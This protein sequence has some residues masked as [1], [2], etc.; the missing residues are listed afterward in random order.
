MSNPFD[1]PKLHSDLPIYGLQSQLL[2]VTAATVAGPSGIAQVAGSSVLAPIL[3]VA[4]TQQMRPDSLLP[5]D[6]EPCLV[7]AV[8][9]FALTP[10]FHLG[11][12]A[13]SHNSLPVYEVVEVGLSGSVGP[14]GPQGPQGLTGATG[15]TGS[16]GTQGTTG[17]T[18]STGNPGTPGTPGGP[19]GPAGSQG[20]PGTQGTTGATGS[21]GNPGTQGSPGATG[22]TGNPGTQ[23]SP[24]PTGSKGDPGTQGSRGPTGS[25]GNPG[26]QGSPGPTGSKGDPGTQGAQGPA[27]SFA[28]ARVYDSATINVDTGTSVALTFDSERYDEGSY[29]SISVNTTR[30]TVPTS[31]GGVHHIGGQINFPPPGT[32][33][34]RRTVTI[35]LNGTTDIASAQV[36]PIT[37]ISDGTNVHI[38]CDYNL[39][40]AD[41]V[42]LYASHNQGSTLAVS[43]EFWCHRVIGV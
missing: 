36:S 16:P 25:T 1:S 39:G 19:P 6:R 21:T 15:S 32:G 17:A 27:G 13:S 29:H 22:S 24:G 9:G 42:E 4:F 40:A 5:R 30:L 41:Y 11:R 20:P 38:S 33:G 28:G 37:S 23:G 14:M 34:T 12:L 43:G 2:R 26:T 10:G 8:R 18:G 3:Y 35:K 31:Y 7:A